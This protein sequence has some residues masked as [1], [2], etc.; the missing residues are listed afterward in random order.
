[1]ASSYWE[2][3]PDGPFTTLIAVT[4]TYLDPENYHL[5]S[6]KQLARRQ[7]VVPMT[8]DYI[9]REETRLRALEGGRRPRFK[10]AG[11]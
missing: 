3:H 9:P 8:R 10:I 11:E 1:M 5:D 6:L 4:A 2:R 7:D